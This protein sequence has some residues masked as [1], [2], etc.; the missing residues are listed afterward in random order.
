MRHV[1]AGLIIILANSPGYAQFPRTV[2][3]NVCKEQ[4]FRVCPDAD[5]VIRTRTTRLIS[6]SAT[7][8][9]STGST[10]FQTPPGQNEVVVDILNSIEG[11]GQNQFFKVVGHVPITVNFST[12]QIP[13]GPAR[14]V[15]TASSPTFQQAVRRQRLLQ[16]LRG[17]VRAYERGL[18]DPP[19]QIIRIRAGPAGV[20]GSVNPFAGFTLNEN[21]PAYVGYMW[22]G[23]TFGEEEAYFNFSVDGPLDGDYVDVMFNGQVLWS[24]FGQELQP[25][26]LYQGYLD[27][28]AMSGKIGLLSF[29]LRSFGN[30]GA[31]FL[32]P[33]VEVQGG[34]PEPSTW[35]TMTLGFGVL[36]VTIRRKFRRQTNSGDAWQWQ[37]RHGK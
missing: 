10:F 33:E 15:G 16:I 26:F 14:Q 21:S 18:Q 25:G 6:Y 1:V 5:N 2:G 29:N 7:T 32:F 37:P 30:S 13:V 28:Q 4:P 24:S 3:N 23:E 9:G 20:R 36:G 34:I 19:R 17:K 12:P 27:P 22:D 31:S 35:L 8:P 11:V